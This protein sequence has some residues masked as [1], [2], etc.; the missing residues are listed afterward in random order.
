MCFSKVFVDFY[1]TQKFESEFI[2]I[3]FIVVIY[4]FNN[5]KKANIPFLLCSFFFFFAFVLTAQLVK[6]SPHKYE[7]KQAPTPTHIHL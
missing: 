2:L 1:F 6:P 5:N 7:N 4:L 3:H